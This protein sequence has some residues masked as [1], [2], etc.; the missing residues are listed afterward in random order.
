MVLPI[1]SIPTVVLIHEGLPSLEEV[2]QIGQL[3]TARLEFIELSVV[4]VNMLK[5]EDHVDLIAVEL[6]SSKHFFLVLDERHL[7]DAES[8]IFFEDLANLLQVFVQARPVGVVSVSP[9]PWGSRILHRYIREAL[10][11]TDEVDHVHPESI[12]ALV[13]PKADDIVDCLADWR[14]LPVK[15]GLLGGV[16]VKIILIRQFVIFPSTPCNFVVSTYLVHRS[17]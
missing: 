6:N 10:I 2:L 1:K 17:H 12:T 14:V 9:L 13:E 4:N 8:I 15:I 5:V 16:Q 11:F 7:T 3:P